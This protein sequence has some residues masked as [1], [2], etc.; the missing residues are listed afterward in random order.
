MI[1]FS[2]K[3]SCYHRGRLLPS[4]MCNEWTMLVSARPTPQGHV[5]SSV[6]CREFENSG[7]R[8]SLIS[9]H[10]TLQHSPFFSEQLTAFQVWLAMG[11]SDRHPPEQ[12]PIVL[13]VLLS[14]VHRLRALDLLGRFLDLGPW[15]V[16][17][18]SFDWKSS[19]FHYND[20]HSLWLLPR[21]DW[22]TE[23]ST[24]NTF[25]NSMGWTSAYTS[26]W[27]GDILFLKHFTKALIKCS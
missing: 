25:S 18:V 3:C 14:Q 24:L 10:E 27:L 5:H 22:V 13:Q 11:S 19:L 9:I 15:A 20:N 12:L 2:L 1:V 4:I 23:Q 8:S 16:N 17:L 6:G 7:L 21:T 26:L